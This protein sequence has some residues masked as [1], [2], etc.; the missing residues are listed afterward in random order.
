MPSIAT[1]KLFLISINFIALNLLS[2]LLYPVINHL[3][4][5][6][7]NILLSSTLSNYFVF[8]YFV[9]HLHFLIT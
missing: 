7:N 6:I 5:D 4:Y 2:K 9:F 3:E 8:Q 1:G